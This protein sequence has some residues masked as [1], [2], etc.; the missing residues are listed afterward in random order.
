MSSLRARL[1]KKFIR[2]AVAIIGLA[3]ILAVVAIIATA[4]AL[5]LF[6]FTAALLSIFFPLIQIIIGLVAGILLIGYLLAAAYYLA[7]EMGW[8]QK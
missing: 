6:I 8:I 2:N 4:V 5:G 7:D 3:F 1:M